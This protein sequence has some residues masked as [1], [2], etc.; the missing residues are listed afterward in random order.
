MD[1]LDKVLVTEGRIVPSSG[2]QSRVMDAVGAEQAKQPT[3][4]FPWGRFAAGVVT[5][6]SWAVAAA[7]VIDQT[8][9]S[10]AAPLVSAVGSSQHVAYAALAAAAS[11]LVVAIPRLRS[12]E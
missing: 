7:S 8:A 10:I 1:P 12:I 9:S 2:F 11:L 4:P 6:A 5:C 3:T